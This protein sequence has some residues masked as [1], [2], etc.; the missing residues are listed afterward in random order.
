M[1]Q[2]YNTQNAAEQQEIQ[3]TAAMQ[4]EV[5]RRVREAV[6]QTRMEYES[7]VGEDCQR[8]A[9]MTEKERS[10]YAAS[11]REAALAEREKRVTERELRA[12]ALEKLA[13]RGLPK[14][15]ADALPYTDEAKCL[16]GIE[17]V[18]KAFRLAV[19][20]AVEQRLK[21]EIPTVGVQPSVQPD[22]ASLSDEEYYR[23]TAA[24]A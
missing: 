24:R 4:A 7:T 13:E 23:L 21:G 6:E 22:E 12:M 9:G 16:A 18:E 19:Q 20:T 14:E 1:E 2:N 10:E 15:L 8:M 3:M 11:R 17:A 5:E